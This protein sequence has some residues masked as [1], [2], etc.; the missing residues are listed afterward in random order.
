MDCINISLHYLTSEILAEICISPSP[1]LSLAKVC[2]SGNPLGLETK[3]CSDLVSQLFTSSI[4]AS[5]HCTQG[6]L[7]RGIKDN[8]R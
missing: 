4:P 5:R 6:I 1:Q 8:M 2:S 3:A 7:R